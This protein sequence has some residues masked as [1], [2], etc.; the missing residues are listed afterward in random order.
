LDKENHAK[1]YEY[2]EVRDFLVSGETFRLLHDPE[3]DMLQTFPV[4]DP[5]RLSLYYESEDYISHTDSGRGLMASLYQVIKK[6]S[7]NKKVKLIRKLNSG[8]GSVADIGAGTGAFLEAASKNGWKVSGV[9]PS[10]KARTF[11]KERGI[12]LES[13]IDDLK[14]Q[15]YDVVTLWHVLEHLPDLESTVNKISELVKPGGSLIIAV[16]NFRSYDAQHYKN[17]WAAYDV[18]RHL[19]HFSR[20]AII[21]LFQGK[22]SY[23]KSKP[24]IFDS[25][26]VSLLSQKYKTGNSFSF[27]AILVGLWSNVKGWSSNE[28]SSHL[29]LF[30]KAN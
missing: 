11:A 25:F 9:E 19:W 29:Y 20:K 16:P 8:Y 18:P 5:E 1:F 14:G 15:Q 23:V 13:S 30:K 6:Y 24:M 12:N 27:K 22:L 28:Y 26:Y 4:P 17:Y 10:V 21:K 7:I 2:L 3:R